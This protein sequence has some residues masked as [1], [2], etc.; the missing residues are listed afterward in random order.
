MIGPWEMENGEF[1]QGL[2]FIHSYSSSTY[3]D[4]ESLSGTVCK[5]LIICRQRIVRQTRDLD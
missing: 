4:L 1:L 5:Y 2:L 3:V